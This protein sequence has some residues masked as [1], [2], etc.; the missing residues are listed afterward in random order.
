MRLKQILDTP[1]PD[2]GGPSVTVARVLAEAYGVTQKQ[3]VR[4]G[5]GRFVALGEDARQV[6]LNSMRRRNG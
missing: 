5:V 1:G 2:R 6:I 4:Y 3:V